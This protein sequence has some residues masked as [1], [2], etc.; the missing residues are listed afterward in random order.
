MIVKY[1]EGTLVLSF[2]LTD[3]IWKLIINYTEQKN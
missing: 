2:Y 3:E 1:R